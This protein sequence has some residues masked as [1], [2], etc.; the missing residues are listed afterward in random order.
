MWNTLGRAVSK[1]LVPWTPLPPIPTK[2]PKGAWDE[3]PTLT[4]MT[5]KIGGRRPQALER[6]S[7]APH[8]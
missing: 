6:R 3:Q 4:G 5:V 8:D 1:G 7:R 2:G